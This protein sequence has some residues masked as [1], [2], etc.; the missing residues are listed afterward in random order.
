M[1]HSR[2]PF[3]TTLACFLFECHQSSMKKVSLFQQKKWI[4]VRTT[5]TKYP[6]SLNNR[7]PSDKKVLCLTR[8]HTACAVRVFGRWETRESIESGG[9]WLYSHGDQELNRGSKNW[10]SKYIQSVSQPAVLSSLCKK[11]VRRGDFK[12]VVSC[13]IKSSM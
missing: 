3:S 11:V 2:D 5:T 13:L 1:D 9:F 6:F 12:K 8:V 4:Y 10:K 7:S